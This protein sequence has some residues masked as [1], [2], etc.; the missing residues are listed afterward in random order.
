[1]VIKLEPP[2]QTQNPFQYVTSGSLAL[3]ESQNPH[4]RGRTLARRGLNRQLLG[5]FP[6]VPPVR[7]PANSFALTATDAQA[8]GRHTHTTHARTHRGGKAFLFFFFFHHVQRWTS[9][10]WTIWET[11]DYLLKPAFKTC[12]S[13]PCSNEVGLNTA[14]TSYYIWHREF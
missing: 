4:K 1:M 13:F 14:E 8:R 5:C 6:S 12:F 11:V 7:P 10:I 3:C 9:H 2:L